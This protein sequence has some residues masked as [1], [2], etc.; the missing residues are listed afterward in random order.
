MA[1]NTLVYGSVLQKKLDAAATKTLTSGWMDAN[2]GQVEYNGG[3]WKDAPLSI[4][5]SYSL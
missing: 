3:N 2:A 1:I 5:I 4:V